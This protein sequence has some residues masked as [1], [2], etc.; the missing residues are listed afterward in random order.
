MASVAAA[1]IVV[2]E[3]EVGSIVVTH[4]QIAQRARKIWEREG[5][6]GGRDQEHW[7][8]AIAELTSGVNPDEDDAEADDAAA[9][10][11]P[12]TFR[13]PLVRPAFG[14]RANPSSI[15]ARAPSSRFN[16][17]FVPIAVI[18]SIPV[19]IFSTLW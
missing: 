2:E 5:K 1:P 6:V 3:V 11:I 7:F 12:A 19:V 17:S 18:F 4:E 8:R 13:T 14:G 16:N 10:P 15:H 9:S